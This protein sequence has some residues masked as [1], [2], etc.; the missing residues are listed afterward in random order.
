MAMGRQ[1]KP[2][3]LRRT[4]FLGLPGVENLTSRGQRRVDK[5]STSQ[6]ADTG[7]AESD[8]RGIEPMQREQE[9]NRRPTTTASGTNEPAA[10][11]LLH[12]DS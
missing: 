11:A 2:E 7:A 8:E 9:A 3:A 12:P 1:P 4:R 5:R 10:S 6:V